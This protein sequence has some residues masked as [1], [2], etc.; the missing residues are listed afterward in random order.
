MYREITAKQL[1][2]TSQS[3]SSWFGVKYNMNIYRGCEHQC[4]YCDSR[5]ECYRIENFNDV[6]IKVNAIELLRK[7]LKKKRNKGTIGTGAMS[8]PYTMAEKEFK[9]TRKALEVIAEFRYPVNIVTKSNLILR[10]VEILQE[11][12]R[13]YACVCFTLTTTD[14]ELARKI[15][16][17]A[18]LTSERLKAM[19]ILSELG[20]T[21]CVT[22]MPILPFIEDNEE[23]IQEIVRKAY[24]YGAKHIVSGIGVTL[25]D[26]QR[27]YYYNKLQTAFPGIKEKYEKRYGNYY[28]CSPGN[29]KKLKQI[30]LEACKKFGI[31]AEM[32]SY[33]K[34]VAEIQMSFLDN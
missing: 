7:E 2:T 17:F 1:L 16:P 32:P 22:M 9:L 30:F 20:I 23:N 15:E 13:I 34:K 3:P 31:S 25:R 21:T 6:Q 10:D 4:I 26:K 27:A 19:G 5:S 33:Y 11:I 24:E 8:D 14:D 18:P 12:N 29:S 28:S